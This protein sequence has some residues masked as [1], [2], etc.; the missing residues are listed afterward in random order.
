MKRP[1]WKLR[2]WQYVLAYR[3]S[4][5]GDLVIMTNDGSQ[6]D[7]LLAQMGVKD[8]KIRF[9][10]NGLDTDEFQH[11][12]TVREARGSLEIS[13]RYVLLAVSRLMRLK[14]VD[15]SIRAL[16]D[17][18]EEYPDTILVIVG[19]GPER[20]RLKQLAVELG[21]QEHVRFEGAVPHDEVPKYLAAADI[22]LSF[23]DWSNVG[24]PL[25]EA[26]MAGKCIVTL[27]NGDTSRFV[28]NEQNGVLLEYEDLPKLSEVIKELL[29]DEQRRNY[30]AAN[31]RKF[32][33]ERFWSWDERMDAEIQA[34]EA[35]LK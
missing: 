22:F 31:A 14:R 33:E 32:A 13:H 28:K 23:Y 17:V 1:F 25:L 27:N 5:T 34:V 35:L 19:D 29:V 6:G 16:P 7:Q 4:S 12:P 30:L 11:L 24:N 21:V 18:V 10:I 20:D 9:W 3:I 2:A 26:M 8:E 15:R